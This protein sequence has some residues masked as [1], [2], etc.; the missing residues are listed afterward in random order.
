LI[1]SIGRNSGY[2]ALGGPPEVVADPIQPN[3]DN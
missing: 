3:R 1:A 2:I